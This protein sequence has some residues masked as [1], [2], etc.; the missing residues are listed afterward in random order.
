MHNF[1]GTASLNKT[2]GQVLLF[3]Y[4]I[5]PATGLFIFKFRLSVQENIYCKA[6]VNFFLNPDWCFERCFDK[7]KNEN[8]D[9]RGK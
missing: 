4:C 3:H 7:K 1:L 5:K 8:S 2:S 9:R 6:A